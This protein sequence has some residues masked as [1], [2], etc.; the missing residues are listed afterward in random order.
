MT[1]LSLSAINPA[2]IPAASNMIAGGEALPRWAASQ[3]I[4]TISGRLYIALF[5]PLVSREV[6]RFRTVTNATAAAAAPTLCRLGLHEVDEAGDLTLLARSANDT[7]L[8]AATYTEYASPFEAAGGYPGAV[9]LAAGVRY[10]LSRL[11]VTAV[12]APSS[13]GVF[14]PETAVSRDPVLARMISGV[15]DI[16]AAI[17]FASTVNADRIA[18]QAVVA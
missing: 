12:A 5:T 1:S 8:W 4:A 14:L 6:S 7:A 17:P 3:N 13:Y 18:W 10:A 9:Q 11:V 16:A 15:G 2:F